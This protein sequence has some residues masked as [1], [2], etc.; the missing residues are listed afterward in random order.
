MRP[1][2]KKQ[3]SV[4]DEGVLD[5]LA[6]RGML[7]RGLALA[8]LFFVLTS[9]L[10]PIVTVYIMREPQNVAIPWEDGSVTITRLRRFDEAFAFHR[11]TANDVARAMLL[12]SPTGL[13]DPDTISLLFNEKARLKLEQLVKDQDATFRDYG[14]HQKCEIGSTEI[15]SDPDGTFRARVKGQLIRTGV[16]NQQLKADRLNF[17]LIVSLFR[18]DKAA[19]N[20]KFPL[21]VW[22][23]D[24]SESR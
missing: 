16:F 18:N 1:T 19:Y 14:Y 11:L 5:T 17:T 2:V 8:C 9:A 6:N 22:N 21:G 12:R 23:F 3:T 24:Y 13:D 10:G 7:I 4:G 20:K 15:A